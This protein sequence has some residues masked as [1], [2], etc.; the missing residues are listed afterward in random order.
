MNNITNDTKKGS[1]NALGSPGA[2]G[3]LGSLSILNV[4]E[5]DI[6]ITFNNNDAAE[7]EKAI[8]MLQDMQRRG[9]AILVQ[10]P[11]NTY[12]RAQKIDA[13]TGS[14]IVQIPE[15]STAST[16]SD[17]SANEEKKPVRGR[18]KK[19]ETQK[20]PIAQ[21]HAVGIARSAGG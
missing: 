12:V 19:S 18:S 20:L 4:G 21:T 11:D 10:L 5:G 2:L 1:Q 13:S 7:T 9:Y 8:S 16:S 6:H 14:Y 15:A 17:D 3:S